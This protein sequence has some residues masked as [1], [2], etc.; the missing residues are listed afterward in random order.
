MD[1]GIPC[2]LSP[3]YVQRSRELMPRQGQSL[4]WHVTMNYGIDRN[5]LLKDPLDDETLQFAGLASSP[6]VHLQPAARPL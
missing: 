2:P 6:S 3:G 1:E 5:V 4:P